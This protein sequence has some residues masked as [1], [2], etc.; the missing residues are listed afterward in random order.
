MYPDA[1]I[2]Y[3]VEFHGSRDWFECHEILEEYWK[4][5]PG[6]PK[7]RT[8]VALIQI[9][10]S[11]YHQRR[12]NRAGAMKMAAASLRNMDDAHLAELGI[13]ARELRLE[14][15]RRIAS[16]AEDEAAPFADMNLPLAD[17]ALVAACTSRCGERGWRWLAPSDPADGFLWHKH[18]LRDRSDVIEARSIEAERRRERLGAGH[19][20][21]AEPERP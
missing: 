14:M 3:L 4:E 21:A 15:E 2:D 16:L 11:L 6:D 20:A 10:V 17:E 12:G 13:L 7:S 19:G 9:A 8:W 18:T 5:H 1:Y